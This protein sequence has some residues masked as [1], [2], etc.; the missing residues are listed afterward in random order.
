[1][2]EALEPSGREGDMERMAGTYDGAEPA[3]QMLAVHAAKSLYAFLQV[4]HPGQYIPQEKMPRYEEGRW[5]QK[6]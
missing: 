3:E 4:T 5:R 6:A 2:G 1:M